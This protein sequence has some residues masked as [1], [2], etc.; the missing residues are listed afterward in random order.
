MPGMLPRP[1]S[2]RL[3]RATYPATL[4][5]AASLTALMTGPAV[6]QA[7]MPKEEADQAKVGTLL[8]DR[9]EVTIASFTRFVQ[10]TGT[11]TRAEREGADFEYAGGWQC[12]SGWIW[13]APDCPPLPNGSVR[14]TPSRDVSHQRPGCVA[15]TP[16]PPG[17]P[18]KAPVPAPTPGR[19]PP[20]Q[21]LPLQAGKGFTTWAQTCGNG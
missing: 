7:Q 11:V 21:V 5:A 14:P 1:D 13:R 9:T 18:R 20:P 4:V 3:I 17:P 2:H 19:V 6:G 16:N 12:R 10:P 8:F 15:P